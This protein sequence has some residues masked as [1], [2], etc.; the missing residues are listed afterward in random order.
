[1]DASFRA[2]YHMAKLYGNSKDCSDR[3]RPI[4]GDETVYVL[5]PE[6]V[7]TTVVVCWSGAER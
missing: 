3:T 6:V 5:Y 1:M 4:L 7:G 2:S